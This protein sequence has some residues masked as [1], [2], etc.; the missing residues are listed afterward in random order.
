MDTKN[1]DIWEDTICMGLLKKGIRPDTMDLEENKKARKR[2][3]NLLVGA[4][5]L[6]QGFVYAQTKGEEWHL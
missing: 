5:A 6:L 1:I 2:I 3:I 4:K